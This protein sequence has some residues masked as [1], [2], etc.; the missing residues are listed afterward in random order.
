M[1]K[2][3]IAELSERTG[4]DKKSIQA[5]LEGLHAALVQN[6]GELK[7]VAF[8]GF[9]TFSAAKRMEKISRDLSTGKNLLLPP[10]IVIEFQPASKL[11]KI[12]E[13]NGDA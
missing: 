4:R 7:S 2:S 1:S 3:F 9:G 5:L 11:R 8:P 6:C 10:E 13:K 12:T